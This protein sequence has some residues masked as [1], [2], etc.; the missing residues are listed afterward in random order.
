MTEPSNR[1]V[2][3]TGI[4]LRQALVVKTV[5]FKSAD[6][7]VFQQN[8]AFRDKLADDVLTFRLGDVHRHRFLASVGRQEI[9]GSIGL[10]TVR[11][12]H[13]GRP[14]TAC[15]VTCARPFDL[16]DLRAQVGEG[17]AAPR[18]GQNTA[19]IE[20]TKM[21]ERFYISHINS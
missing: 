13:E 10:V 1:A 21:V 8:I 18:A 7:I 12:H 14:P 5:F 19:H 6:F 17:L 3:Q 9:S 20:H 11:I 4:D 16:D 2:D 15:I